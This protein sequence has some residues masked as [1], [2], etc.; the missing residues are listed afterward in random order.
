MTWQLK[1]ERKRIRER[2]DAEEAKKLRT[3]KIKLPF[4]L[5]V[6]PTNFPLGVGKQKLWR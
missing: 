1:G 4:L 5:M 2:H 3:M 6:G